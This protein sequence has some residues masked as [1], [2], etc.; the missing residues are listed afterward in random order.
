MASLLLPPVQTQAATVVSTYTTGE[1]SYD[2]SGNTLQLHGLGIV[3][4]GSTWYG[5]G[6]D[7]KAGQNSNAVACYSSTDLRN[8]TRQQNALPRQSSGDLAPGRIV[9]RPKVVYNSSTQTYV[10]YMHIDDASYAEAKVGVATSPTPCGPYTYK[11][12]FRPLNNVSRDMGLFQDTDGTAYLMGE[13]RNY[14]TRIYK[15]SPDYLSVASQVALLGNATYGNIEAPALVKVNGRYFM[16]GSRLSGWSP[17]DNISTTA[18]SLAGP[19]SPPQSIATPNLRTYDSQTGNIITVQGTAGTTY[20]YAGDR[21]NTADLGSSKLVWLPMTISGTTVKVDQYK[22]WDLDVT[23]GTWRAQG[24]PV[25]DGTI[26]VNNSGLLVKSIPLTTGPFPDRRLT[27][28]NETSTA[29]TINTH[30]TEVGPNRYFSSGDY[31]LQRIAD[32]P[33]GSGVIT[34]GK[35]SVSLAP[36]STSAFTLVRYEKVNGLFEAESFD[37]S[38]TN[39]AHHTSVAIPCSFCSRG[40]YKVIVRAL[41]A[42]DPGTS[43]TFNGVGSPSGTGGTK[44]L[45]ITFIRLG[46]TNVRMSVNGGPEQLIS[47]TGTTATATTQTS[48]PVQLNSGNNNTIKFTTTDDY[49]ASLDMITIS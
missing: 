31:A 13:D 42:S 7:K 21:W 9:E 49:G 27:F 36:N 15:L 10:M 2:T 32:D 40:F 23:A 12:S 30:V 35:F 6:E 29:A 37:N 22:K 48:V 41:G 16:L 20:I 1:N 28:I 25:T 11:G 14:G 8:W 24:L 44:T 3:K 39:T 34:S 38:F 5:I 4:V 18:T 47:L 33:E 17:N 46:T 26:S 43:L 45:G 19:W